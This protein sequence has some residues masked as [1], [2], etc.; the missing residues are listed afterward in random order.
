MAA[1]IAVAEI[2]VTLHISIPVSAAAPS[3]RA[4]ATDVATMA[5]QAVTTVG[6]IG[7]T[8]AGG[9]TSDPRWS[10]DARPARC[11]CPLDCVRERVLGRYTARGLAYRR[12]VSV[13]RRKPQLTG[14]ASLFNY[15]VSAFNQTISDSRTSAEGPWWWVKIPGCLA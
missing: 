13:R 9:P 6:T 14:E 3:L 5:I 4:S 15:K 2:I 10:L 7:A 1:A 11:Q 12:A 8:V